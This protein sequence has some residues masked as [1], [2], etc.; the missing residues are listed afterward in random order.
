MSQGED[1]VV[2]AAHERYVPSG[3]VNWFALFPLSLAGALVALVMAVV[4]LLAED[5]YYFYFLTP[6][7]L[8][9]PVF[10]M[11]W[12]C[13]RL[14]KC[15]NRGLGGFVGLL[16]AFIYYAGYWELSY[17]M[18]VAVHGP[19]ARTAVRKI[20]GGLPGLPGY[21][22]FRCK[23]SRP[24][25]AVR[26]RD[27]KPR[28][29]NTGDFV[30]NMIFFAGETLM[31][32]LIAVGL[33]RA[34]AS[35]VFSERRRRWASRLEFRLP[36]TTAPL[37]AQAIAR[38]DWRALAALPRMSS[39]ANANTNSIQFRL[40]YQPGMPDEPAYIS[41][42][43]RL[44]RTPN[45]PIQQRLISPEDL[46][47]LAR[48][49]PDL[50]LT[51][52]PAAVA[53][54]LPPPEDAND[55][56]ASLQRL[57]LADQ[58]TTR[59]L[60]PE[61]RDERAAPPA[62]ADFRDGAVAASRALL[63]TR[64]APDVRTVAHS[65]CLPA[66]E[67][68]RRAL[69]VMNW[70]KVVIQGVLFVGW[71]G[72]LLFGLAGGGMKDAQGKMTPLGETML[73]VGVIGFGVLIVLNL[74]AMLGGDR[75][76]KPLLAGRLRRQ[77]GSLLEQGAGLESAVVRVEDAR[78][79]HKQKVSGEDLGIAL[80]DRAN[81]R[82]LLD[83]LSHRYVIRGEDVTSFWPVQAGEVIS[84]RLDY[85]VGD[86]TLPLVLATTNPYVHLLWGLLSAREVR[87]VIGRY[88]ETL[89][90]E[91]SLGPPPADHA[92]QAGTAV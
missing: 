13:V 38:R 29:P 33:G 57:G 63:D 76:W 85:R 30:F 20:G 71:V 8:G 53:E 36:I 49:L 81:R 15:R 64:K 41:V 47:A 65:L 10:G 51:P 67:D 79:Y 27:D 87:R 40:E 34:T 89:R 54:T 66:A 18:N 12:A 56:A 78:T 74:I 50:K 9:L 17:L 43:G 46:R 14:G 77:P 92:G 55:L 75:I 61:R 68:G 91:P 3:R 44:P 25:D 16:L 48:E 28:P 19:A 80:F 60:E 6:L 86:T 58:A 22:V 24:V 21:V 72:F 90:C 70:R 59:L 42:L 23:M 4:L 62:P 11:I 83:G 1:E 52:A 32:T 26:G 5:D 82:V 7:I 2:G 45:L 73:F 88:T 35:R 37:V 39:V 31:V 84:I 69:K